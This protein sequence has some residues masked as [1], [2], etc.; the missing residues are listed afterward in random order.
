MHYRLSVKQMKEYMRFLEDPSRRDITFKPMS[1]P[2]SDYTR[3]TL[4]RPD[5]PEEE[6]EP[7]HR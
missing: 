7:Y 5:G 4:P 3:I 2:D 6:E 1:W